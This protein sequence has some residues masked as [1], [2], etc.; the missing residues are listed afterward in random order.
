[1]INIIEKILLS[2][3]QLLRLFILF[4]VSHLKDFLMLIFNEYTF[5]HIRFIQP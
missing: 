1:M 3:N 2:N 5:S 4:H